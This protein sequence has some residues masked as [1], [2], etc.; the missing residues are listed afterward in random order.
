MKNIFLFI[1]FIS[2]L[3]FKAQQIYPL[4]IYTDVP[5]NSYIKDLDSELNPYEG[6]W[7]GSWDNKIVTISLKKLNII[8]HI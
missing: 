7:K 5:A 6:T 8:L 3:S 2:A 1:L 4:R